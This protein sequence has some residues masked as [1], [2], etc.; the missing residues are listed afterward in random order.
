M[1]L[2]GFSDLAH[3]ISVYVPYETDRWTNRKAL[4]SESDKQSPTFALKTADRKSF[5]GFAPRNNL[6]QLHGDGHENITSK[7]E[8]ICKVKSF[9]GLKREYKS[10]TPDE[11]SDD[12]GNVESSPFLES[13]PNTEE[14]TQIRFSKPLSMESDS[15][16]SEDSSNIQAGIQSPPS[17]EIGNTGKQQAPRPNKR[18]FNKGCAN[19]S[20]VRGAAASSKEKVRSKLKSVSNQRSA[21]ILKSVAEKIHMQ[22]QNAEF[23]IQADM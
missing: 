19:L 18:L 11:S 8:G 2:Q 23:Q 10:N 7:T 21:E 1:R 5:P 6:G 4:N 20:G 13:R 17:P 14:D 9:D 15:E 16:D 12:A 3:D 22:L